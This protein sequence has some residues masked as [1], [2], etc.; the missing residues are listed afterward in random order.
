MDVT[1]EAYNLG[2]VYAPLTLIERAVDR[3]S[4]YFKKKSRK[5]TCSKK[6]LAFRKDNFAAILCAIYYMCDRGIGKTLS[7]GELKIS[8]PI[9]DRA[10]NSAFTDDFNFLMELDAKY[11]WDTFKKRQGIRATKRTSAYGVFPH[12]RAKLTKID[13][14]S[15]L[16]ER[17]QN[18]INIF[19]E[20][21]KEHT[22]D[23]MPDEYKAVAENYY[24]YC[25]DMDL[26]DK[27]CAERHGVSFSKALK[28]IENTSEV[29][30]NNAE[31]MKCREV[32]KEYCMC[33]AFNESKYVV[34]EVYGRLYTPFHNL[35]K[36][37]RAAFRTKKSGD[38]V[39]EL[40]DMKGAFVKGSFHVVKNMMHSIGDYEMESKIS[41]IISGMVD[42]YA[43]AV[44]D[45]YTRNSVKKSVLSFMFSRPV[46]LKA[47]EN[48]LR[49]V[50]RISFDP[51]NTQVSRLLDF[52]SKNTH[53][54]FVDNATLNRTMK[55][56]SDCKELYTLAGFKG[57]VYFT[58]KK[59][60]GYSNFR[61][62]IQ[63]VE[64][65]Y[66]A[67]M[68]EHVKKSMIASFGSDVYNAFMTTAEILD[69][70]SVSN[71]KREQ[72]MSLNY[73]T[74][75]RVKPYR[76]ADLRDGNVINNSIICQEAEGL[77]MFTGA[78]PV[79]QFSSGCGSLVTLHDAIFCPSSYVSKF[80]VEKIRKA[81]DA[82]Y[83]NCVKSVFNDSKLVQDAI[84][85]YRKVE[86]KVA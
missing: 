20:Y 35:P 11:G 72:G 7:S 51:I 15:F 16:Y 54:F 17:I 65:V 1:N 83:G 61:N 24:K 45:G 25:I 30:V 67:I 31:F 82:F 53:L 71:I 26:A 29:K 69:N 58:N 42:P 33:K 2:A 4:M 84:S 77:T 78:I 22:D 79:M 21:V 36:E 6:G 55:Q 43:F 64:R 44:R 60:F 59:V 9:L 28:Y 14:N 52:I 12:F 86:E 66:S 81:L 63:F 40:V 27:I 13:E 10:Y 48:L 46:H 39:A 50:N 70:A 49:K 76:Q 62:F 8:K 37:Y 5:I 18:F 32:E 41:S 38:A 19:M 47:R 57:R 3:M 80:D 68:T 34:K 74:S 85:K 75:K 23:T 56:F 73:C